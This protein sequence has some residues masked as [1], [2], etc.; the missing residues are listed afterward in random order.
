MIFHGGY[1]HIIF[2]EKEMLNYEIMLDFDILF[3]V[4]MCK[5]LDSRW[6]SSSEEILE[7]RKALISPVA[8]HQFRRY[9]SLK[10]DYLEN[11]VIFWQE[12]YKYKV[13]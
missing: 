13:N 5:V 11:D 7:F 8:S 3:S 1:F 10:G 4:I 12:V 9:V 2:T 6:I